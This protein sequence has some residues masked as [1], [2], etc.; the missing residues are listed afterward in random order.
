MKTNL[1]ALVLVFSTFT[2]AADCMF[3]PNPPPKDHMWVCI[4]DQNGEN[5]RTVAIRIK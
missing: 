2:V 5:C 4:C 3:N 1:I